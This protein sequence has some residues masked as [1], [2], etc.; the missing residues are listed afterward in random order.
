MEDKSLYY[1]EE[2]P[3]TKSIMHFS[4]PMII[5]TLLSVIYSIL[6]IYFIGFLNDSHMISALTLTTPIFALFMGLGN[7]F[8]VGGGTY[9]SRLMGEKNYTKSQQ[10]SSIAFYGAL[11]LG[12]V[13]IIAS[14]PF[15][16]QISTYLGATGM[17]LTYTNEYMNIMLISAP[18]VLLFFALEQLV[19]AVGSP[20]ISMIGMIASVILNI[21]L[22]PLLIFQFDMGVT[23]AALGTLLANLIGSAYYIGYIMTKSTTLSVKWKDLKVSKEVLT[24][25]FKIGIPAFVMSVL[26]GFV[27]LVFNLFLV[28]YGNEA[29]ASYGIQFR[30][31]QFPELI[32]MGLCEGVVPLIAYNFMSNKKRM[33]Q[34]VKTIIVMILALVVVSIAVVFIFGH[35]LVGLFT[36]DSAIINL[37][38]Y[39]LRVTVT[40]L[41]L[42]GVGFML[43]GML[44]A[45]GQG[46]ASM[47][48]AIA[49]GVIIIPTLYVLNHF[50]NLHGVI[51]SLLVAETLIALLAIVIVYSLRKE[52]TVDTKELMEI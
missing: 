7:L 8:G 28:N 16:N 1:F 34:T 38:V 36:T 18:F 41:F 33:N 15:V 27:G 30:L 39:M 52:L 43:I 21:I 37:T 24:E 29:V 47:V 10:V 46:K 35:S 5:G 50:F 25:I 49:Q 32:V 12:I 31:V 4:L 44:Q 48:M 22:D 42:N 20:I 3:I 6:N 9:I 13:I 2:A 26:M 45:T 19:R 40:S 23:G 14:L 17:T 51:W 11:L